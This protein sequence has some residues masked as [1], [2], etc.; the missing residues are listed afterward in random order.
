MMELYLH[1][2]LQH[3][4]VH[5]EFKSGITLPSIYIKVIVYVY[6]RMCMFLHNYLS[7]NGTVSFPSFTDCISIMKSIS[8]EICGI[9]PKGPKYFRKYVCSAWPLPGNGY[10]THIRGNQQ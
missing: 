6:V 9:L 8:R 3:G 4:V 7:V 1:Y 5:N 2:L 10:M